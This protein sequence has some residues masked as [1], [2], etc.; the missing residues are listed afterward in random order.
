VNKSEVSRG[1]RRRA[2]RVE[3][4]L[5]VQL[6][7]PHG[8]IEAAVGDLSRTGLRLR[9]SPEAFSSERPTDLRGA[10]QWVAHVLA[11]Q[12]SLHLNYRQLGPLIQKDVR[13]TR[14]G[15][16]ADATDSVEL[17]C[18]FVGALGE[19]ETA[20]LGVALPPPTER[21][22][23][24]NPARDLPRTCVGSVTFQPPGED[25]IRAPFL[26]DP[27]QRVP[28]S[29]RCVSPCP[30]QRYRALVAGT[31]LD[32]P[33][34]FFCYTDMV[35]VFGVRVRLPREAGRSLRGRRASST[36][37]VLEGFLR[38]Y[39]AILELRLLKGGEDVWKGPARVSGLELPEHRPEEMLLSLAFVKALSLG[40]L[41]RLDLLQR[42]A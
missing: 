1:N 17:C 21:S 11:P 9:V 25:G 12:F 15:V 7:G 38:R 13:I 31:K 37:P 10:A 20:M 2:E 39:G 22:E 42:V 30:P 24:W 40:D 5:P 29:P 41:R 33:A 35:T 28:N 18:E 26:L 23:A 27:E 36:G 32:L 8:F 19:E 3:V 16:P 6:H 14:I 4:G 34:A